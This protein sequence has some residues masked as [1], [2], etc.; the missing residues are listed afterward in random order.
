ML[1]YFSKSASIAQ[2]TFTEI[3]K[4]GPKL[5]VNMIFTN[6]ANFFLIPDDKILQL[7]SDFPAILF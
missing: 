5:L 4:H 3:E 6:E 2:V 7:D 1:G